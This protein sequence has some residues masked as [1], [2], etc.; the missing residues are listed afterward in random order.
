MIYNVTI[1][2]IDAT[3]NLDS[4]KTTFC[5]ENLPKI[6]ETI[7]YTDSRNKTYTEEFVVKNVIHHLREWKEIERESLT[8]AE[9]C[10]IT[11]ITIEVQNARSK[12]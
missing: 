6:G 3:S 10:G 2:V 11:S 12:F 5:C 8:I 4:Y 9:F 7:A 1:E